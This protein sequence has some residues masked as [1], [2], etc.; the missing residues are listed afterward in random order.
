MFGDILKKNLNKLE[1]AS[2]NRNDLNAFWKVLRDIARDEIIFSDSPIDSDIFMGVYYKILKENEKSIPKY[3]C[4]IIPSSKQ[5]RYRNVTRN[6]LISNAFH[7]DGLANMP[8]IKT[9][10][11][12]NFQRKGLKIIYEKE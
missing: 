12:T 6:V 7:K 2:V 9:R 5:E 1:N 11:T 3:Y 4:E 10:R 8:G